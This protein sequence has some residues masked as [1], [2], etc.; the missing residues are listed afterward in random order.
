MQL[1]RL[2]HSVYHCEYHIVIVT[3]YRK[4]IF[5]QGVFAYMKT[6]LAEVTDHYPQ[7]KFRQINHDKDHIH[8]LVSIPPTIRVGKAVG[9]IKTNTAKHLKQKFPFLKQVYWGTDSVWSEG[10]F[11]TTVGVNEKYIRKYIKEQGKKDLGQTLFEA[12]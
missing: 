12:G 4:E 6:R 10:Y 2:A 1:I 3:K 11:V 9:I 7:I 8:M 5:K